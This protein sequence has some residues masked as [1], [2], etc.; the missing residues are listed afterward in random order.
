MSL[1]TISSQKKSTGSPPGCMVLFFLVFL[2]AGAALLWFLSI[3]PLM[4]VMAAQTWTPVPC[5]VID[6]HVEESSDS[7]GT[8]YK[9]VVTSSYSYQGRDYHAARYD[10]T[11]F[12][13][14]G[15]D[16][17]AAVVARYPVG[18]WAECYVNPE[19][20]SEAVLSRSPSAR[21]LVGLFGLLFM[22]P[23]LF[24]VIWVLRGMGGAGRR[25]EAYTV[26][27]PTSPFGVTNPQGDVSGP[28]ELKPKASPMGKLLG[29]LFAALF[30]NGIVGAITYIA[31]HSSGEERPEGCLIAFL[32]LFGLIGLLLIY[33]FLRQFLVLFNPR[34]KLTLSPGTLSP[35]GKGY[36]QWRL[37]GGTG[38]VKH[39]RVVLE[40]REEARYRQGTD[41]TTD[42]NTFAIVPIVDTDQEYQM[43]SGS[44]SFTLPA[45]TMPSF[46]AE[47]NKIIWTIKAN[48]EISGWPDSEEEF[49]I[50][51][52]P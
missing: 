8:T 13:S 22:L 15:Y 18:T 37:A 27:D 36:V 14:S 24:G 9:A 3:K 33:A 16:G 50:L 23:G 49:E 1:D 42:K 46:T 12:L 21:Y 31:F 2:V 45:D 40:G 10:F 47:N 4:K 28:V 30:W 29:T 26:A 48:L 19:D 52:R 25:R 51:V 20:P 41:T 11:N 32:A 38:G 39:L 35:G 5:M 7:D 43:A 44:T 17:K 34:P 6:S